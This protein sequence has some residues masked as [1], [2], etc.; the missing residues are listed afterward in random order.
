[1]YNFNV[2]VIFN[3]YIIYEIQKYILYLP[4]YKIHVMLQA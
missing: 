1:M 4:K 3:V 2:Y